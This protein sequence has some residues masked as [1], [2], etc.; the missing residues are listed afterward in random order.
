[1]Q[2][3]RKKLRKLI[4]EEILKLSYTKKQKSLTG[5]WGS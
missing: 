5:G 1:M 4:L 2:L 3:T